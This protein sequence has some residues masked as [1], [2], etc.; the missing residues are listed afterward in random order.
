MEIYLRTCWD[1]LKTIDTWL[2]LDVVLKHPIKKTCVDY[3]RYVPF[4]YKHTTSTQLVS[5]EAICL[6]T[7]DIPSIRH[8]QLLDRRRPVQN[9]IIHLPPTRTLIPPY[10]LRDQVPDHLSFEIRTL[11]EA[12]VLGTRRFTREI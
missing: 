5:S 9:L 4:R 7:S 8:I 1:K 11:E 6:K 12:K 3:V 10:T 2:K